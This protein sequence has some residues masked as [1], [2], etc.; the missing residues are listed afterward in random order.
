MI[1]ADLCTL[2]EIT[3]KKL[4]GQVYRDY[5]EELIRKLPMND[6]VFMAL[7]VQKDLFI[8]N[9]KATLEA[10][11]TE[12]EKASYFLDNIIGLDIYEYFKKLLNAM[13]AFGYPVAT[14]ARES[15][16]RLD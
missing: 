10:K 5:Q 15:K 2:D 1:H 12:A 11:K 4:L 14:L 9:Q 7:L 16:E 13:E 3:D 6:S 8:G